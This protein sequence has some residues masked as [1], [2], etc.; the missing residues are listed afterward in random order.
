[1][2]FR[3]RVRHHWSGVAHFLI[4]VRH[5]MHTRRILGI[6]ILAVA[7]LLAFSQTLFLLKRPLFNIPWGF[8]H[9]YAIQASI[10]NYGFEIPLGV[11]GF[12]LIRGR[13]K[14]M[15]WVALAMVSFGLW[16]YV[17]REIW[18]HYFVLPHMSSGYLATHSYFTGPLWWV[19][20]RLSWHILFPII[21]IMAVFSTF[22]RSPNQA[23][24]PSATAA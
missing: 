9:D 17:V 11:V 7:A 24:E 4:V 14:F 20:L 1:M 10:K 2:S 21:F 3:F 16:L 18:L 22:R 15:L 12:L 23:Q 19:L 6:L 5:T 8:S 13:A